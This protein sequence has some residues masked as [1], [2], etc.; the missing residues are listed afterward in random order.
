MNQTAE[1]AL[2]AKTNLSLPAVIVGAGPRAS[3]RFVEFFTANIRNKNTREA[4]ARAIGAF[5]N[6]CDQHRLTLETIEPVAVAAYVEK[7]L[8]DGLAKPSVKQHLAAARPM[9]FSFP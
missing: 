4:Y 1:V 5:L 2:L 3:R 7:L 9:E 6:W 8:Q